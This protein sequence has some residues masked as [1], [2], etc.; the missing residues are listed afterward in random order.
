MVYWVNGLDGWIQG[1]GI[2][3]EKEKGQKY[4][5]HTRYRWCRLYWI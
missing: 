3:T 5:A 4:N 2:K 1:S